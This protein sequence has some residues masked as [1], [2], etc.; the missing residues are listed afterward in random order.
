MAKTNYNIAFG[1]YFV[2][3]FGNVWLIEI[4]RCD[5]STEL[6]IPTILEIAHIPVTTAIIS[7]IKEHRLFYSLGKKQFWMLFQHLMKPSRTCP[8]RTDPKK[9]Y[10]K[11][12]VITP[13]TYT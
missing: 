5:F 2:D 3:S 10:T 12:R 1:S 4:G 13:H 6:V 11:F 8:L 7:P 9:V